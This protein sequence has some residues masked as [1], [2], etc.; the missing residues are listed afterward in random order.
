[1]R[2]HLFLVTIANLYKIFILFLREFFRFTENMSTTTIS[3]FPQR[4]LHH[5][6]VIKSVDNNDKVHHR[7][8]HGEL[9]VLSC[10]CTTLKC[11]M[12]KHISSHEYYSWTSAITKSEK[13]EKS[14][15]AKKKSSFIA[16]C[17]P[18]SNC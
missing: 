14:M 13:C 9:M 2:Q 1:M 17:M 11:F 15:T 16:T 5:S 4:S 7:H 8:H 3:S 6:R 18:V 12:C 10:S